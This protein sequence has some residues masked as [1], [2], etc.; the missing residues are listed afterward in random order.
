MYMTDNILPVI[1]TKNLV[2]KDGEPNTPH[3]LTTGMKFSVSNPRFLFR[4][5]VVRKS[6]VHVYTKEL[7][8][9]LPI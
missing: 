9:C 8:T 4:P 7:N 3:K 6:T 1:P 5:C 2:N